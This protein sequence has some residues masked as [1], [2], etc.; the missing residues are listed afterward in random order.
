MSLHENI[1]A[2]EAADAVLSIADGEAAAIA[3]PQRFWTRLRDAIAERLP[4][5]TPKSEQ[6]MTDAQAAMFER[7][8]MPYGIHA[9]QPIARVPL[10]Y[11]DWL[12]GAQDEFKS[13]VRRYLANKR[14][15]SLV[16]S[17]MED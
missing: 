14:V 17:E 7:T 9:G 8:E 12:I 16:V 13:Q 1:K 6:P 4:K 10:E 3:D 15:S 11:L 2:R 5:P